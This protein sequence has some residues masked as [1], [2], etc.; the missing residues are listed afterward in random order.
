MSRRRFPWL[1]ALF[2]WFSTQAQATPA[3]T[4]ADVQVA[5]QALGPEIAEFAKQAALATVSR[6]RRM[7]AVGPLVGVAPTYLVSDQ[8]DQRAAEIT[9]SFGLGLYLWSVPLF[10]SSEWIVDAL[11]ERVKERLEQTLL[12]GG[13]LPGR[14]DLEQIVREI[15]ADLRAQL[16]EGARGR[17]AEKPIGKLL[18]EAGYLARDQAWETRTTAAVGVKRI[19]VGLTVAG[20]FRDRKAASLGPEIAF[21]L[22]LG[23][24]PRSQVV[25]LFTRVDIYLNNRAYFGEQFALGARFMFDLL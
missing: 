23:K 13:A 3:P 5:V 11:K 20:T 8:A 9:G 25:D 1:I 17:L 4:P 2:L 14:T 7:V 15:W 21:H 12:Q 16:L 10:P 6:A 18:F 22:T 24:G 19:T